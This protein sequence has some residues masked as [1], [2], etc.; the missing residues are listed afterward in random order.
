MTI[1]LDDL[2][3]QLRIRGWEV[4]IPVYSTATAGEKPG[5]AL[6]L[7]P[8][9]FSNK[10]AVLS[11]WTWAARLGQ[12]LPVQIRYLVET[13]F[14]PRSFWENASDNLYRVEQLLADSE[15]YD[16]VLL[17]TTTIDAPGIIAL[18]TQRHPRVMLIGLNALGVVTK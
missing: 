18:A 12:M 3:D 11:R 10:L 6:A 16:V 15:R 8:T 14:M 17:S 1:A 7:Q 9:N 13:L 5:S 2:A 4:D